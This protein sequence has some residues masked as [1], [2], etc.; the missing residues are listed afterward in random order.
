MG[1]FDGSF[2]KLRNVTLGYNLPEAV[3]SKLGL[4]KLRVYVAGQNLWFAAKYDT[5]DPE[6]DDDNNPN[7]LPELDASSTPTSRLML[8]GVKAQF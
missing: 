1:H 5:F 3:T 6:L 4:S 7:D 8:F 2:V